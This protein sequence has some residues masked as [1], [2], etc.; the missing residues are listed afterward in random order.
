MS[1]KVEVYSILDNMATTAS[2]IITCDREVKETLRNRE[3]FTLVWLDQNINDSTD[4]KHMQRLL[5]N[6]NC[7]VQFYTDSTRCTDYLKSLEEE[8]VFII[9]SDALARTV[10]HQL[11]RLPAISSVFIFSG[12]LE[13]DISLKDEYSK[14][15]DVTSN[16]AALLQ[17][18]QSSLHTAYKQS[19]AFSLF[20]QKQKSTKDLSKNSASFLW[21]QLLLNVLRQMPHDDLAKIQMIDFCR[22]YYASNGNERELSRINCFQETYH[23]ERAFE[24]YTADSFLYRLLNKAIRTEDME[25]LHL[26]RF[27]IIDLCKNLEEEH[28]KLDQSKTLTLYRG[29]QLPVDEL[30]RLNENVDSLI[31]INGFFSTSKSIDTALIFAGADNDEL[32]SVLFEIKADPCLETVIFA[33]I[34]KYSAMRGEEEVLFSLGAV[35]KIESIEFDDN[36]RLW[37]VKMTATDEASATVQEYLKLQKEQIEDGN[38]SPIILFGALLWGDM[39]EADKAEKYFNLLLKI[40]PE[41]H[42]DIDSVYN[43]LGLIYTLKGQ[44][45]LSSKFCERAYDIQKQRLHSDPRLIDSSL[46]NIGITYLYKGDFDLALDYFNQSLTMKKKLY[47]NGHAEEACGVHNIGVTHAAKKDYADALKWITRAYEMYKLVLPQEHPLIAKS[48]WNFALIYKDQED[49]DR[50]LEYYHKKYEVDQKVYINDHPE[51]NRDLCG[52]AEIYKKKGDIEEGLRF[53]QNQLEIQKALL[54]EIHPRIA[55]TMKTIGDL[56][57]D[58]DDALNYYQQALDVLCNFNPLDN[59]A[60]IVCL[61]SI[62]NLYFQDELYEDALKFRLDIFEL[63]TEILPSQHIDSAHSLY[64]LGSIEFKLE[65]IQLSLKYL[66]KSLEIYN[67][68]Y[69]SDHEK[70]KEVQDLLKQVKHGKSANEDE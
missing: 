23:P 64:W 20:D 8:K 56:I 5:K 19:F 41:D 24:W 44:H 46:T 33:D 59:T 30:K 12:S 42:E 37:L 6:F 22:Q 17:S 61:E 31:S 47:P 65:H 48:L 7:Y 10:L 50:A 35:F 51:L 45:N 43:N 1:R 2:Q 14:I 15:I 32:K 68:N 60:K 69:S 66:E 70:I 62:S 28:K 63:Q 29:Q 9:V 11:Q 58:R 21:F 39:G 16:Q 53:C 40:L 54:G 25:L 4:S 3:D 52:I 55:Y 34:D 36:H 26:F 67:A 57:N 27:F 49:Y 38:L 18:V 13:N